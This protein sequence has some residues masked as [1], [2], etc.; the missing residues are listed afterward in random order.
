[1]TSGE[2]LDRRVDPR[3]ALAAFA[4]AA[5]VIVALA[6][7][8]TA[9]VALALAAVAAWLAGSSLRRMAMRLLAVALAFAPLAALT[10]ILAGGDG[11]IWAGLVALKALAI[12][13]AALAVGAVT[14]PDRL[15]WA[16]RRFGLPR[17]VARI[18]QV[19]WQFQGVVASEFTR[20]Q[21]AAAARGF[22]PGANGRSLRTFGS[23][24]AALA[25]RSMNRAHRLAAA[26]HCRGGFGELRLLR[27]PAWQRRDTAI[28]AAVLAASAAALAVDVAW[29][30]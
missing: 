22:R 7:V 21:T 19:A 8:P 2:L 27:E 14:A 30:F 16:A 10:S 6:G 28:V 15:A 5:G 11:L 4:I 12:A 25:A 20:T 17:T 26:A 3:A 1:M 9:A 23:L 29:R 13:A 24:L 18:G